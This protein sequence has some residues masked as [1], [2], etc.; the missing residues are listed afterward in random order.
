MD[1]QH[2]ADL[3]SAG[4]ELKVEEQA[5]CKQVEELWSEAGKGRRLDVGVQP[6]VVTV[7]EFHNGV[8]SDER[9][10]TTVGMLT[11]FHNM[12]MKMMMMVIPE[13]PS[14]DGSSLY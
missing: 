14:F 5:D 9:K 10:H 3:R 11:H 2:R 13:E 1:R 4:G 12:V 8:G 6:D 7:T